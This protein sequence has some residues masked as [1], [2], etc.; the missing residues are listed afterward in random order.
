MYNRFFFCVVVVVVV[1]FQLVSSASVMSMMMM[2]FLSHYVNVLTIIEM[3]PP[4]AH[5]PL[6][7]LARIISEL[8]QQPSEAFCILS[9][10]SKH[11]GA[12]PEYTHNYVIVDNVNDND[13][14]NI[15]LY[16]RCMNELRSSFLQL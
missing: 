10:L 3:P 12:A 5:R 7:W 14:D 11:L 16:H 13:N 4:P 6:S 15:A 9:S 2:I 8:A 1:V